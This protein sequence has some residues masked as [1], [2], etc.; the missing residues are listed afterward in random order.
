METAGE[1]NH[2][3]SQWPGNKKQNTPSGE[4][5]GNL[6]WNIFLV[7]FPPKKYIW[8][9]P[10]SVGV[11]NTYRSPSQFV[12]LL[13]YNNLFFTHNNLFFT[14][15]GREFVS[16]RICFRI[17]ILPNQI[18]LWTKSGCEQCNSFAV[19]LLQFYCRPFNF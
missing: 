8:Y 9:W 3:Q 11:Y 6:H 1:S 14:P 16:S 18:L 19:A 15:N 2:K 13:C 17:K 5:L 12:P 7:S 4:I 10:R